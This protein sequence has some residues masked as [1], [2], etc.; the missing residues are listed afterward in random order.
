LS[1]G[2]LPAADLLPPVID[3]AQGLT[4]AQFETW[5]LANHPSIA[6][7]DCQA[8][9][10][11]NPMI[12]YRAEDVGMEGTAGHQG[13][14]IS[15]EFVRGGKLEL[16]R[17]AALRQVDVLQQE[18]AAQQVR[19]LTDVRFAYYEVLIAEQGVALASQFVTNLERAVDVRQRLAQGAE[20]PRSDVLQAQAEA[21]RAAIILNRV[22]MQRE[23][24]WRRLVALA[25]VPDLALQQLT[26]SLDPPPLRT[27]DQALAGLLST[28][29][30]VAAA[31]AEIMRARA[32]LARASAEP[33][34]NVTADLGVAYDTADDQVLTMVEIGFPWPLNNRNQGNI[35]AAQARVLEASRAADRV[36]LRLEHELA[37]VFQEYESAH[38]EVVTYRDKILPR[39]QEAL[40][41]AMRA[42]EEG[43]LDFVALLTAQ[44]TYNEVYQSYLDAMKLFWFASIRLEGMLLDGSV[45]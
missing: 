30:Q 3:P 22:K 40:Q 39:T 9:L 17:Q 2:D 44:Q 45:E 4:L 18:L 19:V 28:S 8:G 31:T 33:I 37:S 35:D 16:S 12:G 20:A 14:F 13:A 1:V 5:A 29:P 43:E 11:P 24:A 36:M 38:M 23:G 25:G 10:P 32:E 26:G 34:P 27:W 21:D 7:A 42:F 15:R 41:L 6:A